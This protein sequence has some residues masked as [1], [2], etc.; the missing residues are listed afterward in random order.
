M[1]P[2]TCKWLVLDIHLHSFTKTGTQSF[3]YPNLLPT[4][5]GQIFIRIMLQTKARQLLCPD[6]FW[7]IVHWSMSI[8]PQ[9]KFHNPPALIWRFWPIVAKLRMDHSN[10]NRYSQNNPNG[11]ICKMDCPAQWQINRESNYR[12]MEKRPLSSRPYH[13]EDP[14]GL[15]PPFV[16]NE[17]KPLKMTK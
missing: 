3:V 15:C 13:P 7:P 2:L 5:R 10:R 9:L 4:C 6:Y 12:T 16:K 1:A 11:M 14:F 17:F 8:V